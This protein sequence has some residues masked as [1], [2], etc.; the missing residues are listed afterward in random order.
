MNWVFAVIFTYWL[1]GIIV[2]QGEI[3]KARQI[4]H[5]FIWNG[6]RVSPLSPNDSSQI[7]GRL[8]GEEF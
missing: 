5:R 8:G 6:R 3:V 2:P 1:N 4:A 7:L